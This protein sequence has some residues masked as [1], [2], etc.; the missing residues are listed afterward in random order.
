MVAKHIIVTGASRSGKSEWAEQ[1]LQSRSGGAHICYVAPGK[2]YVEDALW[3]IRLEQHKI[4]RP[5]HWELIEGIDFTYL[6][7]LLAS[8]SRYSQAWLLV[9]S[10]G[11]WVAS[12]LDYSEQN[13]LLMQQ[14]LLKNL[15]CRPTPVLLVSEEVGW[16][17]VPSTAV[18]GTFRD[19]LG[20]LTRACA[21]V[22]HERWLVCMGQALPLHKLATSV[23]GISL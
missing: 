5:S 11:S 10:L 6:P 17:V 22:C 2:L 4:R 21:G 12:G 15:I 20:A 13:W 19:R 3:Q 8:N 23:Q 1:L 18:G 7:E 16:G 14:A 9:D